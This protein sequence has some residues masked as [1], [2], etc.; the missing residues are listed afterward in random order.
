MRVAA[1]L[2]ALV[3]VA[4]CGSTASKQ[5]EDLQSF[6]AAG[7]LLAHDAGEGA[8]W[9]PYRRA[10]CRELAKQASSLESS[11]KTRAL[12]ALAR[13]IAG[14]LAQLE[15]ADRDRARVLERRF[16]DSAKRAEQLT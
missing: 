5:A 14:D 7:A 3:L 11:A 4:G 9:T 13:R 12:S 6:A 8:E 1:L 16:D 2:V 10:H 15:R